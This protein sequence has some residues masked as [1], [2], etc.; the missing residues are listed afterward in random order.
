M[1]TTKQSQTRQTK[2][3]HVGGPCLLDESKKAGKCIQTCKKCG[4]VRMHGE[5]NFHPKA[6]TLQQLA[7]EVARTGRVPSRRELAALPK[8]KP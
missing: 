1:A 3:R 8:V 7:D 2:C 5:R 4:W 6:E